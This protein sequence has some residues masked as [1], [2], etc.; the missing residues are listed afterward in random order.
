MVEYD[1]LVVGPLH[2]GHTA[3]ALLYDMRVLLYQKFVFVLLEE[4]LEVV[5]RLHGSSSN[6]SKPTFID[7]LGELSTLKAEDLDGYSF[8]VL[9]LQ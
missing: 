6:D 2:N 8:G 1:L 5:K 7:Y 4:W 3:L 9:P